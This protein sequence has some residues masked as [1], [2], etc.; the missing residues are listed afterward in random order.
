MTKAILNEI[1]FTCPEKETKSII[2][3]SALIYT[4]WDDHMDGGIECE[5]LCPVCG[6]IHQVDINIPDN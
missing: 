3:H 5:F 2:P 1:T 4:M 6:N